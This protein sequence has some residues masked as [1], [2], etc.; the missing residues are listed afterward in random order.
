MT[1]NL[2]QNRK[3]SRGADGRKRAGED[4]LPDAIGS[5][6]TRNACIQPLRAATDQKAGGSN[7]S[8]RAKAN[9]RILRECGDFSFLL[10]C[11]APKS[12]GLL[13]AVLALPQQIPLT[14]FFS[15]LGYMSLRFYTRWQQPCT[16]MRV[17]GCYFYPLFFMRLMYCC[18][19][20][21]LSR[22]IWSVT[23]PYTSKVNAAVA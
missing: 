23:W 5:E 11:F 21:A 14:G 10:C 22:F 13:M 7:P 8:R 18:I 20:S 4:M 15:V 6:S 19:R 1:H 16:Q 12:Y 2:T 17:Q 3:N 9:P